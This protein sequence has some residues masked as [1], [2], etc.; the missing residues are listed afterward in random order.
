MT[1]PYFDLHC[2]T[3]Y[4]RYKHPEKPTQLSPD[5]LFYQPYRQVFAIWS[6]HGLS[7]DEAFDQF[8]HIKAQAKV[9]EGSLLAVEGG[10]L[11]GQKINRLKCLADE[12]IR[13]LTLMWKDTC[14]L[15]GAWN[16]DIGL[17]DFGKEV[18]LACLPLGIIPDVSHASDQAFYDTASLTP[19]FIATHSNARAVCDHPR[20]LTD[21]M[22]TIIKN[23]H[24]LVGIS[25]CPHHL[26]KDGHAD[27]TDVLRHIE[28]YMALGGEN[29]IC[30]GCDFDGIET[31]PNGI[32]GPQDLEHIANK[33]LK[34]GYT[35]KQVRNLFYENAHHYFEKYVQNAFQ[36]SKTDK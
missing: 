23:N 33:M 2:D 9:P 14:A 28:H 4:E 31:T 25:M 10:A 22:F 18:V 12:Q 19:H 21:D 6:E 13:I 1:L 24:G 11:L 30:F 29:T 27:L 32:D 20:N 16:T 26:A 35:E 8:M 36:G 15:G 3:L 5:G 7:S 17:T 34:L